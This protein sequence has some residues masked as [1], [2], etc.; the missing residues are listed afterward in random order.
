MSDK[1]GFKTYVFVVESSA[2]DDVVVEVP[3]CLDEASA[4]LRLG[5]LLHTARNM[6]VCVNINAEDFLLLEAK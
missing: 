6:G 2:R 1:P 5:I 3:M 4:R